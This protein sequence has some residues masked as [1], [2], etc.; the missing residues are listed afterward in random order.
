MP[1]LGAAE[2]TDGVGV[3]FS[4]GAHCSDSAFVMG[5][6]QAGRLLVGTG[7]R[8]SAEEVVSVFTVTMVLEDKV[9]LTFMP[10]VA[11]EEG[12]LELDD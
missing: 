1:D 3:R 9:E 10:F 11:I 7:W 4:G 2:S 8:L 12:S 5:V 6:A